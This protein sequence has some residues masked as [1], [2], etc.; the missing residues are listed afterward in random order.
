MDNNNNKLKD[1]KKKNQRID[2]DR[3]TVIKNTDNNNK[4]RKDEKKNQ[5]DNEK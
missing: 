2:Y 4:K 1:E 3:K 5:I